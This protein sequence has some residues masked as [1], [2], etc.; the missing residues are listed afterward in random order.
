MRLSY[1]KGWEP[2]FKVNQVVAQDYT[3][4]SLLAPWFRTYAAGWSPID[5]EQM[6]LVAGHLVDGG[7]LRQGKEPQWTAVPR[8]RLKTNNEN[9]HFAGMEKIWEAVIEAAEATLPDRFTRDKR[10]T[11]FSCRLNNETYSEVMGGSARVD[12]ISQLTH[13]SY[14][15]GTEYAAP[16]SV[17]KETLVYNAEAEEADE[18]DD[19]DESDDDT[20]AAGMQPVVFT[21][22]LAVT[23]EWKLDDNAEAIANVSAARSACLSL[24]C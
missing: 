24:H 6:D 8:K 5:R 9:A 12:A 1:V 17:K 7:H 21:A 20:N 10:T 23:Y 16:G 19:D 2:R 18:G 22:D 4:Q 11:K 13:S 15:S 14:P 3:R